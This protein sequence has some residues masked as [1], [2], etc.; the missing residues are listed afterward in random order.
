M[1]GGQQFVGTIGTSEGLGT[2]N[3][4]YLNT[5]RIQQSVVMEI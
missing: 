2:S 1:K 4:G 3:T 5:Y